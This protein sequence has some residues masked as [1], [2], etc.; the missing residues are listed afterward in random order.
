M[1]IVVVGSV[2]YD[3]IETPSDKREYVLGGSAVYFATA[4]SHFAPVGIVGV[5]GSDY[6]LNQLAFLHQRGVDLSGI[7]IKEGKTFH[8]AGRYLENLN[9]RETL[10][11]ELNV[12]QDFKPALPPHFLD[13]EY[14]FLGNINPELQEEVLNKVKKP[15]YVFMD[16]I[17][18]WINTQRDALL[19]V[20]KRVDGVVFND[21]EVTLLTGES[22]LIRAAKAVIKMGPSHVI[23]KKG[24][25]GSFLIHN[26]DIF[27]AP[28]FPTELVIDPT[29][30]GDTFAGGFMGYLAKNGNDEDKVFRQ[31]LLYGSI[32]ASFCVEGFSI[33]RLKEVQMPEVQKRFEKFKQ[34][35]VFE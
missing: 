23:V 14:L 17:I 21:E 28:A 16:T 6:S 26:E 4:A 18:L 10:K 7:E 30:A 8:W 1:K 2:A 35:L 9:R 24:E 27:F 22:N 31:A 19:R 33:E 3:T 13:A 15:E 25:H 20:L 5:V 11:T 34:M 32:M 29:G 12:F